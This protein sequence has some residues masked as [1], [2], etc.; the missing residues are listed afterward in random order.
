MYLD[1]RRGGVLDL[2]QNLHPDLGEVGDGAVLHE[3]HPDGSSE[4]TNRDKQ[5]CVEES[6]HMHR[7]VEWSTH[8]PNLNGWQLASE[9]D[10]LDAAVQE[11]S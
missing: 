11:K 1:H 8:L 2:L 9:M 5:M 3:Q 10:P 4:H 7:G 6:V